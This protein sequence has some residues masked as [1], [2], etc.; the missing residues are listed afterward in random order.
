MPELGHELRRLFPAPGPDRQRLAA[1]TAAAASARDHR[2]VGPGTGK[3]TTVAR[4]VALLRGLAPAT[5][6]LAAP[7]SKTAARLREAVATALQGMDPADQDRVGPLSASTLHR[8]LRLASRLPG[9]VPAR[10]DQSAAARRGDRRQ[11]PPWVSLPMMARLLEAVRPDA[12]LILV[13][14]ADPAGVHRRGRSAPATS[15]DHQP[16]RLAASWQMR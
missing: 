16:M 14:D 2:R 13:G 10:P 4:I 9:P 15:W 8:L 3:T 5:V 7:A 12:R 1:A 11:R 6:A